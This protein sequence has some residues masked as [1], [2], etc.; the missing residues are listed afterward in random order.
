M[1]T[2]CGPV[3]EEEKKAE[4]KEEDEEEE[5]IS[6]NTSQGIITPRH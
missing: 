6:P 4:E 2:F 1:Q 3:F 5:G